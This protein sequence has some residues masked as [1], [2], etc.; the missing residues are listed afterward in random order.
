MSG[1]RRVF[2]VLAVLLTSF[3]L[4]GPQAPAQTDTGGASCNLPESDADAL[5]ILNALAP[6]K[7]IWDDTDL[8]VAIQAAPNVGE[9]YLQAIHQ[10]I[11]AWDE[12]LRQC[13]GGLIT[14]TDVTGSGPSAQSA[15]IVVHYVP[16]AGGV[17]FAGLAVCGG[18]GCHNVLV[19]TEFAIGKGETIVYTPEYLFYITL[20]ELGHALGLGHA[21][22]LRE[23]TDLMGYGWIG[24]APDPLF[25]Q[26]D[27]DALAYIW[28]WALEGGSQPGPGPSEL[29]TTFDCSEA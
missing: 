5:Y 8:T 13:F 7:Y 26:C 27:L 4:V 9:E 16:R 18:N 23:S 21:T 19:S 20:H 24:D 2:T 11:A 10:A 28:S 29:A 17:V 12:V 1:R 14:L 3:L 6:N 15:D 22:N 25:S